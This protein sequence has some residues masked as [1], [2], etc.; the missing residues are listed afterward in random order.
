M[1]CMR[2]DLPGSGLMSEV[3]YYAKRNHDEYDCF[4]LIILSHGFNGGIYGVDGD[5]VHLDKV[6]MLFKPDNCRS[7]ANKP[8]IFFVQACQGKKE[9]QSNVFIFFSFSSHSRLMI[10]CL[11]MQIRITTSRLSIYPIPACIV[12]VWC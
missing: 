9:Q 11:G 10:I 2:N 1:V 7:L 3:S 5:P 8:K 6:T 4:V 12:I